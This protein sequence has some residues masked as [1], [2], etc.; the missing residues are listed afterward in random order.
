M[1]PFR[2]RIRARPA[3]PRGH[4]GPPELRAAAYLRY[5]LMDTGNIPRIDRAPVLFERRPAERLASI[6]DPEHKWLP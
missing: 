3:H 6:D 4:P 2:A 1:H 5:L